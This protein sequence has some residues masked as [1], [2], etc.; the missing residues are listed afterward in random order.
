MTSVELY[1]PGEDEEDVPEGPDGLWPPGDC[2][3]EDGTGHTGKVHRI[4]GM[5]I[6]EHWWGSQVCDGHLESYAAVWLFCGQCGHP[7]GRCDAMFVVRDTG[8]QFRIPSGI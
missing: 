5:C 7:E 8:Q 1:E 2:G 3:H 4:D 6:H